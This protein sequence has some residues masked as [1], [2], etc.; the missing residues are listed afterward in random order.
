MAATRS[1]EGDDLEVKGLVYWML[2][3]G[4]RCRGRVAS[5]YQEEEYQTEVLFDMA[6]LRDSLHRM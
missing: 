5:F 4:V 6:K 2:G 1:M 3:G